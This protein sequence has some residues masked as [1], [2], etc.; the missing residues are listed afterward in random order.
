MNREDVFII[1]KNIYR[2][3][4]MFSSKPNILSQCQFNARGVFQYPTYIPITS[5]NQDVFSIT[6]IFTYTIIY[7]N[8]GV[9]L[10]NK[11]L[12][13]LQ[14]SNQDASSISNIYQHRGVVLNKKHVHII[15]VKHGVVLNNKHVHIIYVK[16]GV[17][18]NN[19]HMH[20][21]YVKHGVVLNNKHVHIIYVKHGVVL[22]TKY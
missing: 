1:S 15:Y 18:L 12:S 20:I 6:N 7:S 22:N 9:F 10:R 14:F 17:V 16:H 4:Q 8:Q 5:S 13:T 21:I 11:Y 2:Q 3:T 19:K